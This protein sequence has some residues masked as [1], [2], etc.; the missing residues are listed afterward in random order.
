MADIIANRVFYV[1]DSEEEVTA[2]MFRFTVSDG[3]HNVS[4]SKLYCPKNSF[5]GQLMSFIVRIRLAL[6]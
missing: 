3:T 5:L 6:C 2:D 1:H 4:K